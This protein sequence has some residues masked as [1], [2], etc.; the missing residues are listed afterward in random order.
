M[1]YYFVNINEEENGEHEVHRADCSYL[2]DYSNCMV[3]GYFGD[4]QEAVREAKKYFA[5]SYGC[6]FCCNA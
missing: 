3:I 1:D 2:T 6:R 4:G 5:Q